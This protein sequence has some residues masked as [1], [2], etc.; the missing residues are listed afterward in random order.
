MSGV[1]E[2]MILELEV[3]RKALEDARLPISVQPSDLHQCLAHLLYYNN[4]H[5]GHRS[6]PHPPT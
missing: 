5:G 3:I 6:Y 1:G 2:R 4:K